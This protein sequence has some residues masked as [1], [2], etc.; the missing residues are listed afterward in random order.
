MVRNK[1][2]LKSLW[3]VLLVI[4]I[5]L[6][7]FN[8]VFVRYNISSFSNNKL[9]K[10]IQSVFG[11]YRGNWFES[12]PELISYLNNNP[13]DNKYYKQLLGADTTSEMALIFGAWSDAYESEIKTECEEI[14]QILSLTETPES[15]EAKTEFEKLKK[16]NNDIFDNNVKFIYNYKIST[17]GYGTIIQ[18]FASFDDLKK[19]RL[20]AFELAELLNFCMDDTF[21]FKNQSNEQSRDGTKPLKK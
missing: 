3:C 14:E 19:K 21:E 18:S 13:I 9:T 17:T 20:Y 7:V 1:R 8:I 16:A 11:E 2:L 15:I 4:N 5:I 12:D 10:D 6:L